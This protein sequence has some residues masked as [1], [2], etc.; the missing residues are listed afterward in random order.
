[1]ARRV[2]LGCL[3]AAGFGITGFDESFWG[4]GRECRRTRPVASTT[5]AAI[6]RGAACGSRSR[7]G[8]RIQRE[9]RGLRATL[10][11]AAGSGGLA[12][13]GT[14]CARR[15]TATQLGPRGR[16]VGPFEAGI[17]HPDFI[18]WL[19]DGGKQTA[20]FVDPG[21]PEPGAGTGRRTSVT[22]STVDRRT[23]SRASGPE[24]TLGRS[25]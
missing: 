21:H 6:P 4:T 25:V 14:E 12:L 2:G 9:F 1:M 10:V 11:A 13:G 19:V 3:G 8:V 23:T 20:V 15:D 17:F 16:G 5:R 7:A 22:T 18:L 24:E